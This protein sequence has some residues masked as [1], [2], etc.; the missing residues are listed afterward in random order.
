[1]FRNLTVETG[2]KRRP[3][4]TQG[5][6]ANWQAGIYRLRVH[7]EKKQKTGWWKK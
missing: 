3:R 4:L 2:C 1:M 6:S 5:C 7:E